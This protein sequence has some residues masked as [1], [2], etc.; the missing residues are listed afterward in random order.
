MSQQFIFIFIL[1]EEYQDLH[2]EASRFETWGL[3]YAQKLVSDGV[4]AV[5]WKQRQP[6]A[7]TCNF[8]SIYYCCLNSQVL[9]QHLY[10]VDADAIGPQWVSIINEPSIIKRWEWALFKIFL[11]M[12][13]AHWEVLKR[14]VWVCERETEKKRVMFVWPTHL[15][16]GQLSFT[17]VGS[18]SHNTCVATCRFNQPNRRQAVC[19]KGGC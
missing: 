18:K 7:F 15:F 12:I 2:R 3:V 5:E 9:G 10:L 19:Q 4:F 17:T 16:S 1:L 13:K 14:P 11:A 6:S 8:K